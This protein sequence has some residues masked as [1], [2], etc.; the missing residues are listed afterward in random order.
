MRTKLCRGLD[1][2]CGEVLH[3]VLWVFWTHLPR[4]EGLHV[5]L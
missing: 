1:E 5:F 3:A 4:M 2:K